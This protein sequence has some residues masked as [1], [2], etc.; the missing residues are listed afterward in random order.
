MVCD[1]QDEDEATDV[2]AVGGGGTAGDAGDAA[3]GVDVQRQ[4]TDQAGQCGEA[5]SQDLRHGA[6]TAAP[7][8][9]DNPGRRSNQTAGEK[10]ASGGDEGDGRLWGAAA[11]TAGGG[12]GG[13]HQGSPGEGC[14]DRHDCVRAG[15][16]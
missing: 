5:V 4:V 12:G 11:G 13:C 9:G 14:R 10:A 1:I 7:A 8:E 15:S 2:A 16:Q 6:G 3:A